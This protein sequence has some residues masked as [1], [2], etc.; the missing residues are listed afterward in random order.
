LFVV[1]IY[2]HL[3]RSVGFVFVHHDVDGIA[4]IT[5]I[6]H[7]VLIITADIQRNMRRV[8]AKRADNGFIQ[9]LHGSSP[10]TE[11]SVYKT[12]IHSGVGLSDQA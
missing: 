8:A 11:M 7:I 10:L 4:A 5:A 6:L 9:Q 3:H 1:G 2:K 12:R